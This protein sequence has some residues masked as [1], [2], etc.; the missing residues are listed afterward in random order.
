MCQLDPTRTVPLA[1]PHGDLVL[2]RGRN[3]GGGGN[4][5]TKSS[6]GG[7]IGLAAVRSVPLALQEGRA[8]RVGMGGNMKGLRGEG[9]V[10][11]AR[12]RGFAIFFD[13]I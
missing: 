7:G 10:L 13:F 5:S 1:L 6:P 11:H 2:G 8:A 4:A 3:G 12:H 9:F